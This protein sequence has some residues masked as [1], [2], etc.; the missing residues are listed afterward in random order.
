MNR[1]GRFL[2][3]AEGPEKNNPK[4]WGPATGKRGKV[5]KKK[6]HKSNGGEK[7]GKR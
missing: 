4:W 7:G 2:I 3:C 6:P 1:K 5:V